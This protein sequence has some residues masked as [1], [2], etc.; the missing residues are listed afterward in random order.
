MIIALLFFVFPHSCVLEGSYSKI[1]GYLP[2]D[3]FHNDTSYFEEVAWFTYKK[4]NLAF[5]NI[6]QK[7][8]NNSMLKHKVVGG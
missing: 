5:S 8:N 7:E 6:V 1:N 4:R 2:T 3:S